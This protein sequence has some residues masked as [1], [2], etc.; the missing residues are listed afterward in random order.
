MVRTIQAE[1]Q[2]SKRTFTRKLVW[3]APILT[4]LLSAALGFGS[5]FQTGSFNWWY[6]LILP[7]ALTLMCAGVIQKD[8]KKLHYRAIL[9]LPVDPAELW[10]AK[11]GVCAGMLFVSCL[12]FFVGVT[13]GG[14]VM[15]SSI[16]ITHSLSGDFL[17]FLTFLWQIPLCL[18]LVDRLGQ[19]AAVLINL[20]GNVGCLAGAA[21]SEFWWL[22]Y[23]IPSRLMC[24][25]IQ[26]LPN[27]LPVPENDPLLSQSVVLPGVIISLVLFVLLSLLTALCFRQREAR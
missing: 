7:G 22:P 12:V 8:V 9:S 5:L 20:A 21:T 15:G 17:L 14:F 19:F 6:A 24:P 26:V 25:V 16:S 11:I 1:F 10:M 27:G 3:L 18:F 13:L 2:K 4:L 23:A